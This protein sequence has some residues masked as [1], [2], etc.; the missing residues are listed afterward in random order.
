M[1]EQLEYMWEELPV[2]PNAIVFDLDY[3]PVAFG[4]ETNNDSTALGCVARGVAQQI[5][6]H[7][8]QPFEIALR[9]DRK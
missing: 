4:A 8:H 7:L 9:A 6:H 1:G 5:N 3:W 2:Y